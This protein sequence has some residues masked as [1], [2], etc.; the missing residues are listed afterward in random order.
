[1][2][3]PREFSSTFRGKSVSAA[4]TGQQNRSEGGIVSAI[5][6]HLKSATIVLG[7]ACCCAYEFVLEGSHYIHALKNGDA[8]AVTPI[9]LLALAS[10]V[11]DSINRQ[12]RITAARLIR[13][14]EA[15]A[16]FQRNQETQHSELRA[17]MKRGFDALDGELER[18]CSDIL[19]K[20]QVDG[21]RRY[22]EFRREAL[23][24]LKEMRS[25]VD[26]TLASVSNGLIDHIDLV[27]QNFG[28]M[29]AEDHTQL[30][31]T[32]NGA[33]IALSEAFEDTSES[34]RLGLLSANDA[35]SDELRAYGTGQMSKI[36]NGL[37]ELS[38]SVERNHRE[39]K[40]TSKEEFGY[41][42]D[43]LK[44]CGD[45]YEA[46]LE[47]SMAESE[48]KL[49]GFEYIIETMKDQISALE[50]IAVRLE[51]RMKDESF[52]RR[53]G[54]SRFGIPHSANVEIDHDLDKLD[55]TVSG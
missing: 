44:R 21:E 55:E 53:V 23:T 51:L 48:R 22:V 45:N 52:P 39:A 28:G 42:R 54:R 8:N 33:I 41:I 19:L 20:A 43:E 9:V 29:L 36:R 50:R 5:G 49:S 10:L 38:S 15:L 24:E 12:E 16:A 37:A 26:R 4:L 2:I 3:S 6:R 18:R 31:T 25:A 46:T 30:R 17:T 32:I 35:L 7:L 1:M 14:Q 47:F 40:G 34:L 11:V 13:D 27:S